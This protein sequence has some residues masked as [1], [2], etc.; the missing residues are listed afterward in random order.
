[1]A[2]LERVFGSTA[3]LSSVSVDPVTG[4]V[5]YPAGSTVVIHN[6]RNLSQAHLI[7]S[8][9]NQLTCLKFS[10]NGRYIAT[11]EFGADPKVRIWEL[12]HH[13]KGQH[14]AGGGGHR[15]VAE[16]KYHR[17]GITCVAFTKDSTQLISVGNQHDK[18][19]VLW[20]WQKG[21]KLAENR[22]TSQVNA[23]DV[24]D[25][26]FVTVG[27]RHVKFWYLEKSS[28]QGAVMLQ[29]RS[30]IL[31]DHRNN[32]FVDVCCA[33]K[34]RTFAITITKLLVEF[35]DKKLV[36]IYEL[37]GESPFSLTMGAGRLFIG[38]GGGGIRAF[39][40]D[41]MEVE[42]SLC[43]PHYLRC[44]IAEAPSSRPSSSASAESRSYP[45]VHSINYHEK[46]QMLTALYADRS[47]YH[48]QI[49]DMGQ[50]MKVSSQL[51][52]VGPIFDLEIACTPNSHYPTGL[53]LTGGADETIRI[54]NLDGASTKDVNFQ[55]PNI[56]SKELRKIV[57]VGQGVDSLSEQPDKNFG[58]IISDSVDSTTGV[59]C[60]K[61]SG[62]GENLA[63]GGRDGNICIF[64]LTSKG[65]EKVAEFEAHDGEVL[66]LEYSN[67]S[68]GGYN[69]L[70][71]GSRDRLIH[72]FDANRN[73]EHLSV[74]DD[75]SSSIS[76]VKFLPLDDRLQL[77][78]YGT[79][80][81]LVIREV[82]L[83]PNTPLITKRL[84][85]ITSQAGS[86]C[87]NITSE[88]NILTACQDR[89]MRLFSP[90]GK[91]LKTSKGTNCDDGP[92]TKFCLDP[93]ETF[94]AT[95]CSDRSVYVVDISSGESAAVLSGQSDC[96][97]AIEF[98]PDCR[99]LI[100][101]TYSGC[102][103][104]WRLSLK[105][106]KRMLSR[107]SQTTSS[108]AHLSME[109]CAS[110]DS[111][112]ESG[113]DS[114]SVIV[115]KKPTR[116]GTEGHSPG[117]GSEF[118]SLTS[119]NIA[120]DDQDLDSGIGVQSGTLFASSE[121]ESHRL[122]ELRRIPTTEVIR[123][124]TSN[125]NSTFPP[126]N[127]DSNWDLHVEESEV[128]DQQMSHNF[129][130]PQPMMHGPPQPAPPPYQQLHAVNRAIMQTNQQHNAVTPAS[131]S[132]SNL[133]RTN[134]SPQRTR[135]RWNVAALTQDS[136]N[137]ATVNSNHTQPQNNAPNSAA[138]PQNMM[139]TPN[140]NGG[141]FMNSPIYEH[142]MSAS[143]SLNALRNFTEDNPPSKM[144][145]AKY[146]A[147]V[148]N[149]QP[150]SFNNNSA[151]Y[152]YASPAQSGSWGSP[153]QYISPSNYGTAGF[154]PQAGFNQNVPANGMF[155]RKTAD[156]NSFSKRY[157][158]NVE[159][160][161]VWTP[162]VANTNA[163]KPRRAS[164]LFNNS[165]EVAIEGHNKSRRLT[166]HNFPPS[167]S[168][169]PQ[170]AEGYPRRRFQ[171]RDI[172]GGLF[173]RMKQQQRTSENDTNESD[174]MFRARSQSPTH[175]AMQYVAAANKTENSTESV[176]KWK[177]SRSGSNM[178]SNTPARSNTRLSSVSSH[179]PTQMR[180]NEA[181]EMLKKSQENISAMESGI[182]SS[183]PNNPSSML[184]SRS[185]GNLKF[186][187]AQNNGECH[188]EGDSTFGPSTSIRSP[189]NN[190]LSNQNREIARSENSLNKSYEVSGA[191]QN[192]NTLKAQYAAVVADN[193][194]SSNPMASSSRLRGGLAQSIRDLCKISNPDLTNESLF[195]E[196]N[197]EAIKMENAEADQ[198]STQ[199]YSTLPKNLRRGVQKKLDKTSS[200]FRT[201]GEQTTTSGDSDNN[202][203]P[204]LKSRFKTVPNSSRFTPTTDKSPNALSTPR[205]PFSPRSDMPTRSVSS[206]EGQLGRF[207]RQSN[208]IY[209]PVSG[210]ITRKTPN[211][212]AQHFGGS[213]V[214]PDM[215]ETESEMATIRS[216]SSSLDLSGSL[217][218]VIE[219]DSLGSEASKKMAL[220][221]TE[222]IQ[223]MTKATDKLLGAR[224]LITND[225]S[226]RS[227]EKEALLTGVNKA[228]SS[229]RHRLDTA[230]SS[231][232]CSNH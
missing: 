41:S 189:A 215:V 50:I 232:D 219:I 205:H 101:V 122:F 78:T 135:R 100:V 102:I 12:S 25:K 171:T 130:P 90:A 214:A 68:K 98:T 2:K 31:A 10:P 83:E 187:A 64:D 11:G 62:S 111:L 231:L 82:V 185:I 60:L 77:I 125:L 23:M 230:T 229:F 182:L 146:S 131:R 129:H 6:P 72:L 91:L 217:S 198:S 145:S 207:N 167:T 29:G 222:C 110:P 61:I 151:N 134:V 16:L 67:T 138:T 224:H 74:I 30:A 143:V 140:G 84:N 35:I 93:S 7:S 96:V 169:T 57:Y 175:L 24:C 204:E 37:G 164:N 73:Y 103:F 147:G 71:S 104:V 47:L 156:R 113:S 142:G 42:L 5:A 190:G 89:Q 22:L 76:S 3:C 170:S 186:S 21:T 132:M 157:L 63:S 163:Q 99:R 181:R 108:T 36:N 45:D 174:P 154:R 137:Y 227:T 51:F 81:L 49:G 180:L 177:Q 199:Y 168:L 218:N 208:R 121:P 54:W 107:L 209:D 166:A 19:V 79:D 34:N 203:T 92:L 196:S 117:I 17:L 212:L 1:M 192:E 114:A 133:H 18:S 44:D 228:V 94:A 87:L 193:S 176:P 150:T 118:G 4:L 211:Y 221:A 39:N 15:Q 9:K 179:T 46:S 136:A 127:S 20:D 194:A 128:F 206:V 112:I 159:E 141:A 86:N 149:M 226:I 210:I 26:M 48:W 105:I 56:Y 28:N 183:S 225:T 173:N 109:R 160:K 201:P 55:T 115:S 69:L 165:S 85:Q 97:T 116:K 80:K 148:P 66:C 178:H 158:N 123:R 106:T 220:H 144:A 184:R 59:R 120:E 27:V 197:I 155:D 200:R 139:Y 52:H 14:A 75:H 195:N 13:E 153:P 172:S 126:G 124:S 70:A 32:T 8:S 152:A 58:G 223:E 33:N 188:L 191:T 88:G 43:K 38:F 53:F 202:N 161:T 216:Q 65:V 40:V 213:D 95:V 162:A 119:V